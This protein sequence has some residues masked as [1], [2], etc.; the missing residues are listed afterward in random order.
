[1]YKNIIPFYPVNNGELIWYQPRQF[2][3]IY[4]LRHQQECFAT[5]LWN[6]QRMSSGID[7]TASAVSAK[8]GWSFRHTDHILPMVTVRNLGEYIPYATFNFWSH[9][10]GF[11]WMSNELTFAWER[12]EQDYSW[13][14]I[15]HGEKM[16]IFRESELPSKNCAHVLI[17]PNA[18]DC[19][20]LV[21]ITL[22][23]WYL[24]LV[25]REPGFLQNVSGEF[26][27]I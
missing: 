4:E 12:Q 6:K 1:M 26:P 14:E 13:I 22:L 18:W 2:L 16:I 17:E 27:L 25:M 20:E 19:P 5:L 24:I 10:W 23:G 15:D 11:L 3:H 9:D 8:G 7:P 21:L